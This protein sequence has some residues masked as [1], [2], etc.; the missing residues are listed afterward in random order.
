MR[1]RTANQNIHTCLLK[2]DH[3][4][5]T[6]GR[7]NKKLLLLGGGAILKVN[8]PKPHCHIQHWGNT[9]HPSWNTN[10]HEIVMSSKDA[11]SKKEGKIRSITSL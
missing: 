9:P 2:L 1:N 6:R 11:S 5:T 7:L 3:K 4:R 8:Q 10:Y